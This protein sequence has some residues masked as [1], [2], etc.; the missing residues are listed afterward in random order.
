[1]KLNVCGDL[2]C[3]GQLQV[4]TSKIFMLFYGSFYVGWEN[5]SLKAPLSI[6]LKININNLNNKRNIN[7]KVF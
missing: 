6:S 4:Y 1:M 7:L 5:V 2:V 3:T